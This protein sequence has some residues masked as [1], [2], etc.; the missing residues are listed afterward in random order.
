[1]KSRYAKDMELIH[2]ASDELS[3]AL[4]PER[5][6]DRI[7]ALFAR[8]TGIKRCCIMLYDAQHDALV[9][10]AGTGI[11]ERAKR[12]IRFKPGQGIAGRVF[13]TG[14]TE[15]VDDTAIDASYMEFFKGTERPSERLLCLS[16]KFKSRVYG[17]INLH[18]GAVR[19][20]D[21]PFGAME[22]HLIHTL[23]N[24]SAAAIANSQ[25]YVQSVSDGLT[26]LYI[27]RY[28]KQ[29]LEYEIEIA[30]KYS[31][32]LCLMMFD[33]DY[34]KRL[35]DTYGHTA[36]DY[37][38]KNLGCILKQSMRDTDVCA[39]YG[40]EEFAVILS[41]TGIENA[42]ESAER[43]RKRVEDVEYH[44]NGRV[45]NVTVSVGVS[46]YRANENKEDFIKR[47]DTALYKAKE[48]GRNRSVRL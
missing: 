5:L 45:I 25:F 23:A 34:F 40:G 26:E 42:E 18:C 22:M 16:L 2:R 33:I 32:S 4:Q 21:V 9:I 19:G 38:L 10:R 14:G 20:R 29:R 13:S 6:P 7:N 24:I 43:F 28:F 3:S 8:L 11:S 1:M 36:G 30:N 17:V 12:D 46:G 44:F 39:R 31:L 35:N 48:T 37:V 47:V 27:H 41:D 15:F